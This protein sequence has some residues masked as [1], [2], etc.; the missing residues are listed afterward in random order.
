M[1]GDMKILDA[2]FAA[3]GCDHCDKNNRGVRCDNKN[4][5]YFVNLT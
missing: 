5:K 4:V 1:R 2:R 3:V